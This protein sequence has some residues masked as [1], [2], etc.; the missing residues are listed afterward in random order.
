MRGRV[1]GISTLIGNASMPIAFGVSGILLGF[2]SISVLMLGC[3]ISLIILGI[4]LLLLQ[5]NTNRGTE[6]MTN[7]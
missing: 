3:G 4:S 2:G 1:F 7:E 5:I 6:K